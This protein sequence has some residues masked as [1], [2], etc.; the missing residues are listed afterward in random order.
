MAEN[1]LPR[2][3][4]LHPTSPIRQSK[5]RTTPGTK[6]WRRQ[7]LALL[8]SSMRQYLLFSVSFSQATD[9]DLTHPDPE[10]QRCHPPVFVARRNTGAPVA[11]A[12]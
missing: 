10:L 6:P 7:T 8:A 3:L 5:P 9:D 4:D 1:S 2:C 12:M 11:E